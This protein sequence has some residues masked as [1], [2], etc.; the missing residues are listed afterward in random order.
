MI[1][2]A[3]ITTKIANQSTKSSID[4]MDKLIAVLAAVLNPALELKLL[5]TV[6]PTPTK[7]EIRTNVSTAGY[8]SCNFIFFKIPLLRAYNTLIKGIRTN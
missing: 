1:A 2:A 4:V 8:I 3:I 6:N 5:S 7:M